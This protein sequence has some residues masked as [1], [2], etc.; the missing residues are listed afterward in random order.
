MNPNCSQLT[1]SYL[2]VKV[3]EKEKEK[4]NKKRKR[5]ASNQLSVT[6]DS[7]TFKSDLIKIFSNFQKAN[8]KTQSEILELLTDQDKKIKLEE[9]YT[10][11][12]DKIMNI[13]VTKLKKKNEEQNI[14]TSYK[15]ILNKF[16][17]LAFENS[18]DQK[19]LGRLYN[20]AVALH[21][22]SGFQAKDYTTLYE[23]IYEKSAK[24]GH[25]KALRNLTILQIEKFIKINQN[26]NPSNLKTSIINSLKKIQYKTTKIKQYTTIVQ[27]IES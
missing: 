17:E 6:A 13:V 10:K 19:H 20:Y 4:E 1:Y 24:E 22:Y 11:K 7:S 8:Q 2:E 25:Q 23:T 9:Y 21:V 27:S 3:I 15:I 5:E 18:T 12:I 16:E 14:E 26:N